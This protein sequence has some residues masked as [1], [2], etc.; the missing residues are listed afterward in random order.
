MRR[1][2]ITLWPTCVERYD[3]TTPQTPRISEIAIIAA[4]SS[5]SS[6]MSTTTC[7]SFVVVKA[8]VK[9][10]FCRNAGMTPRIEA[11]TISTVTTLSFGQ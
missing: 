4:T 9:T 11:K 8:C 5:I 7:W 10:A 6:G 3:W 1:S 2:C